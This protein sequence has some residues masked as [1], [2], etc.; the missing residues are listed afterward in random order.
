MPSCSALQLH[1]RSPALYLLLSQHY[2]DPSVPAPASNTTK[3]RKQSTPNFA[4]E[5][6]SPARKTLLLGLR[7]MPNN[8]DLWREYIK[9][10]IGWVEALRRRWKVLGIDVDLAGGASEQDEKM[11]LDVQAGLPA[12]EDDDED[13]A[14]G[15]HAFGASGEVARKA[16]IRGDLI[17]TVLSS[18]FTHP[19]LGNDLDFHLSLIHLFRRYPT[20]LRLRLLDAVY[21]HIEHAS[22]LHWNP[23]AQRTVIERALYD[24]PYDPEQESKY[25]G[26]AQEEE[27]VVLTGEALVAELGKIVKR[28]RAKGSEEQ[29][30][31]DRPQDWEQ[32]WNEEVGLW[33]LRWA[34]H[35]QVVDNEA[36]VS[37]SR[38]TRLIATHPFFS[39]SK[40]TL[41][42]LSTRSPN[43]PRNRR[44]HC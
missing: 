17:I 37:R 18:T 1:P 5:N 11:D 41:S 4:I 24:A 27:R 34:G 26:E 13:A 30:D 22:A 43:R 19:V 35:E 3:R 20:G 14:L 12:Q 36:L 9:L 23:V 10:E 42:P 8:R 7:F 25:R 44:K 2:L 40:H 33:L 32:K 6:V 29:V 21:E 15:Q 28:L 38:S 16:I 31:S 39:Y